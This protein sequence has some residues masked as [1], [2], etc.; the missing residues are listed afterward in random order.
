MNVICLV[1]KVIVD[2]S[3]SLQEMIAAGAYDYV[4]SNITA[5]NFPVNGEGQQEHDLVLFHFARRIPSDDAIAE[6]ER[7]GYEPGDIADLLALG[8]DQP[9]LQRQFPIVALKSVWRGPFGSRYVPCLCRDGAGRRLDLDDF[10]GDW[11]GGCRF[12]ARRNS[13]YFS[14][15]LRVVFT[16]TI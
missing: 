14:T 1:A 5:E 13:L 4:N 7:A 6:M 2:Y 9:E 12:L 3:K 15:F 11:N 8:A 10:A 16:L